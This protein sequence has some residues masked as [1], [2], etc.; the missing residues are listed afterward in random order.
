[1]EYEYIIGD[2]LVLNCIFQRCPTTLWIRRVSEM[3]GEWS[4]Q[5]IIC[6]GLGIRTVI[7]STQKLNDNRF[8]WHIHMLVLACINDCVQIDR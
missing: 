7:Q 6:D 8:L 3:L 2:R 5:K 1:M 4:R